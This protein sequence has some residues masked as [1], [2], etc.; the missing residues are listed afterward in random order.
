MDFKTF[1]TR[2]QHCGEHAHIFRQAAHPEAFDARLAQMAGEPRLVE[3][4]ILILIE[5]HTFGHDDYGIGE[6]Q[7]RMETG[8]SAILNAHGPPL[9]LKLTCPAGCQS[10]EA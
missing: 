2:V 7:F 8:A 5:A 3:G 4:G 1:A 10:R 6:P 9:S